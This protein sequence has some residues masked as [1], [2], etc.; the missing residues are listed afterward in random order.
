[1]SADEDFSRILQGSFSPEEIAEAEKAAAC[2][3][4][5]LEPV[6]PNRE[7]LLE[8]LQAMLVALTD[9][10]VERDWEQLTAE[11]ANN[12][13]SIL[14][15]H[16]GDEVLV[17]EPR[18]FLGPEGSFGVLDGSSEISGDFFGMCVEDWFDVPFEEG[19]L[20]DVERYKTEAGLHVMIGGAALSSPFDESR[21]ALGMILVPLNHGRPELYKVLR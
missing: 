19:A 4:Y 5:A 20:Q 10:R 16:S 21:E 11:F 13:T 12:V 17:R 2:N 18:S 6:L 15:I 9:M 1:M 8:Y 14:D 3:P 7:M